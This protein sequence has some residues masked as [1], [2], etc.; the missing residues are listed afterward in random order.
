MTAALAVSHTPTLLLEAMA[1]R[2][3]RNHGERGGVNGKEGIPPPHRQ[4]RQ[5]NYVAEDVRKAG[6]R[7]GNRNACKPGLAA[8]HA[9]QA[10]VKALIVRTKAAIAEAEAIIAERHPRRRIVCFVYEVD[11]VVRRVRAVTRIKVRAECSR[12]WRRGD[13]ENTGPRFDARPPRFCTSPPRLRG[14]ACGCFAGPPS[15]RCPYSLFAF[16][17]T[18]A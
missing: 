5:N 2:G 16:T 14:S 15:P 18:P 17:R 6:A 1:R 9:Y 12:T 13:A 3:R 10:Q 4:K 7:P 11:G 8:L